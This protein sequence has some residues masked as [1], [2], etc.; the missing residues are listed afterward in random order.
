MGGGLITDSC[1]KS[2]IIRDLAFEIEMN[3][4]LLCYL[5]L[6][7][8]LAFQKS[9]QLCIAHLNTYT[10]NIIFINTYLVIPLQLY[11]LANYIF[12]YLS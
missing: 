6:L 2:L 3:I 8:L 10:Y 11:G 7:I 12:M 1:W 9:T 4:F 5:S